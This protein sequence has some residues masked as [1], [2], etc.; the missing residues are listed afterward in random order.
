M[1]LIALGRG[2]LLRTVARRG[3]L[4]SLI[5]IATWPYRALQRRSP[6]LREG[7][8]FAANQSSQFDRDFGVDTHGHLGL[9]S[10]T[11]VG[12][13][14]DHGEFYIGSDPTTFKKTLAALPIAYEDFVF[15]DYGS[16]K[17]RALLLA[18]EF[19]FKFIVGVEFAV[20]LHRVC[21]A[22][23]KSFRSTSS[24]C[25]DIRPIHQDAA[26]FDPPPGPLV[27]YFCNPFDRIIFNAVLSRIGDSLRREPRP[28]WIVYGYAKYRDCLDD[29]PFLERVTENAV[30]CIYRS[31]V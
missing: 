19:P 2:K 7:L 11:V 26:T 5:H 15:I 13:N 1:K 22:N 30:Y 27:L 8:A 18:S 21:E 29:A 10:L 25:L 3:V 31:V 20:E 24:R 28:V 6:H 12:A 16:G 23:L 4:G 17:G 14:R 9:E